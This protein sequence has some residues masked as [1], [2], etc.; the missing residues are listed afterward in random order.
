MLNI[1]RVLE[2]WNQVLIEYSID[3]LLKVKWKRE[4]W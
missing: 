2:L 1:R 3:S 4:A